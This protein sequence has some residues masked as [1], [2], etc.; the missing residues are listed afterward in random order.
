MHAVV[1]RARKAHHNLNQAASDKRKITTCL[2][3]SN[4][5]RND[6]FYRASLAMHTDATFLSDFVILLQSICFCA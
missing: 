3:Q 6:D 4:V 5:Q 1:H 2:L